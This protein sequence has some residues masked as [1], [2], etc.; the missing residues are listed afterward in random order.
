MGDPPQLRQELKALLVKRLRLRGV[1]PESIDDDDSLLQGP[2][3]LDSIDILEL[4]L[5]VEQTYGVKI[6]DEQLG[7]Q[8]FQTIA[9]L[10]EFV[11]RFRAA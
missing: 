6:A 10:A 4:A 3:G 2:L 1:A 8:A 7:Q 5:A 9:A 11:Q